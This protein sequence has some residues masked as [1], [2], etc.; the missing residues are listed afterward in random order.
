[1]PET[2]ADDYQWP[3]CTACSH[4]LRAD[5]T[6]RWACRLCEDRTRKRLAELPDLFARL[7]TTAALM[8]GARRSKSTPNEATR[9][10]GRTAPL[11]LRLGALDLTAA[12]GVV[13]RLQA[14]EDA[15]RPVLGRTIAPATDGVRIFA[16][17]RANPGSAVPG[18]IAFISINLEWACERYESVSQ[19][20]EE[21]R[22]LHAEVTAT[23]AGD[24]R[25]GRVKIGACPVVLGDGG[26]CGTLLTATATR[27]VVQCGGCG[28]RWDGDLEWRLLRK[29]QE[30]LAA[31]TIEAAA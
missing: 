12:G 7:N 4:N 26:R 18:H 21:I 31:R 5:E 20:I 3:T 14:I 11:P 25:A 15:W 8:P 23:L 27:P 28:A 30:E 29:A 22:R 1:M 24:Q 17:W 9:G 2:A 16:P 13:T 6:T 10:G 19:D